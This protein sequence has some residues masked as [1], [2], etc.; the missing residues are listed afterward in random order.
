MNCK[1]C[2]QPLDDDLK[3][4]TCCGASVDEP[5]KNIPEPTPANTFRPLPETVV[6][7]KGATVYF[8]ASKVLIIAAFLTMLFPFIS[9]IANEKMS[10]HPDGTIFKMSGRE[11]VFGID[12]G[13]YVNSLKSTTMQIA[14]VLLLV[15]L[16]LPKKSEY[17]LGITAALL[18]SIKRNLADSYTFD[19]K[20]I[21]E[22]KGF[23]EMKAHPAFSVMICFVL[24]AAILA[25]IDYYKRRPKPEVI[26]PGGAI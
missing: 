15:A 1:Y 9:M 10:A 6:E 7:R 22:W 18:I 2:G 17:L 24:A 25:I 5:I 16:F 3:F 14:A 23:I 21:S 8:W 13:H 4:C 11:M 20:K 12:S 26:V 19:K